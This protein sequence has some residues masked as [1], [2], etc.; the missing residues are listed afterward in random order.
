[1]RRFVGFV[2]VVA[3]VLGCGLAF[4]NGVMILRKR[5]PG[6]PRPVSPP[7]AVRPTMAWVKEATL[8][9]E[10]VG[11]TAKVTVEEVF[12][13]PNSWQ[14]EGVFVFPLPA[15]AAIHDMTFWM[16]GKAHKGEMLDATK[17]REWYLQTVYRMRDPA[18]LE[19]AGG[20][21]VRLRI[22]PIPAKGTS[23]VKF[24]YSVLM[25]REGNL[26]VFQ[27]PTSTNK[28]SHGDIDD[29][30][31]RVKIKTQ[32]PLKSI[33]CPT[34]AVETKRISDREAE[35]SFEARKVRPEKD[36][37]L[38]LQYD[39][40]AVG[41]SMFSFC[42]G[43][44]NGYFMMLITPQYE[45]D[46]SKV[47]PKDVVFVVDTSGSMMHENK[48]EQAKRA[49][50]Y[51]IRKMSEKDRFG[52]VAFSSEV[53]VFGKGLYE[54]T[55]KNKKEACDWVNA[56]E[57]IGGT[58]INGA[59]LAALDMASEEN[60]KRPFMVVFLTDG[61][62][63]WGVDDPAKILQN[64][65]EAN[66][67]HA[68]LFVFG[69]GSKVNVKLLDRLAKENHGLADYIT[70]DEKIDVKVTS[71]F[72]K[73]SSPVLSHLKM[74]VSGIEVYDVFPKEL[75]DLF[76]GMQLVVTGRYRGHG[77]K[78]IRL[79]GRL[80]EKEWEMEYEGEFAEADER[81]DFVARVWAM[82]K[83]AEL[84]EEIGIKGE[85]E[86]LKS[87]VVRLARRFGILTPYTSYLVMEENARRLPAPPA[88]PLALRALRGRLKQAAEAL[89][90]ESGVD[91]V[92]ARERLG[93]MG[94][95]SKPAVPGALSDRK[96]AIR[97]MQKEVEDALGGRITRY[98][99]TV[100][101]KTF[102]FYGDTW[103]DAAFDPKKHKE[104][105][106]VTFMSEEYIKL[107]KERPEIAKYLALGRKVVVVLGDKAYEVTDEPEKKGKEDKEKK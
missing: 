40:S 80:L 64:V 81:H 105:I 36:F 90:K 89:K 98:V 61:K 93:A 70:K 27:Y 18:L 41:F 77:K 100:G 76:K 7:P 95:A 11:Q 107:L 34:Y 44:E 83:I 50:T 43:L 53:R 12:Y 68:R 21:M 38:Y 15:D 49:L 99:K 91:A 88:R 5:L 46:A 82:R 19:Y 78:K 102:Y 30:V 71:F 63:T 9:V 20:K 47:L 67:Y 14:A 39:E 97:A 79:R 74:E 26:C 92:K 16:N 31:I 86:E 29:F 66:R 101:A 106:K 103:Y 72:D 104:R 75:P 96:G 6:P 52:I 54:A 1:M 62:P 60:E 28:Y 23:R 55:E 25:K 37:L 17:A 65:K 13:N 85:K 69:V 51:C 22:F 3:V 10:I 4:A 35:V 87:E 94:G 24:T 84:L 58:D 56:L 2:V 8:D 32:E 33:Y 73:I 45:I 57:A 42:D 59:L 48:M